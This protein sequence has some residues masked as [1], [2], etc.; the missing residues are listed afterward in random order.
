MFLKSLWFT[1]GWM[2]YYWIWPTRIS[3][4]AAVEDIFQGLSKFTRRWFP[5][6]RWSLA[7][8]LKRRYPLSGMRTAQHTNKQSSREWRGNHSTTVTS[9][10]LRS[11]M[12][13]TIVSTAFRCVHPFRLAALVVVIW[14]SWA[15]PHYIHI[16][17]RPLCF[18]CRRGGDVEVGQ[19]AGVTYTNRTSDL[20]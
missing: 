14:V 11:L 13:R 18:C 2:N 17:G 9:G 3:S 12:K 1:G 8:G 20:V 5:P 7:V 10:S 19:T 4:S 16:S 6:R 15:A